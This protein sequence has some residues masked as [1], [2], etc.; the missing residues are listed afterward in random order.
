[1]LGNVK[2]QRYQLID[3]QVS[4]TFV[5][6]TINI[7]DQP[8]LRNKRVQGIEVFFY[9]DMPVSPI[10]GN[11]VSSGAQCSQTSITLYTADPV[12][13]NDTGE[14]FYRLPFIALHNVV[15]SSTD[16]YQN[17]V[18]HVDDIS[19]QWEKCSLNFTGTFGQTTPISFLIGVYYTSRKERMINI[20][21]KK[22][23]GLNDGSF[24]DMLMTKIMQLE[25]TV[26]N[27]MQRIKVN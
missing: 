8:M 15:N 3:V 1:M 27:L 12:S 21:S 22:I 26:K 5:G 20:L 7:P 19:I 14:Y 4:A 16:P 13:E 6:N 9:N 23:S 25:D 18:F 10:T 2:A 17:R 24:A 11:Q